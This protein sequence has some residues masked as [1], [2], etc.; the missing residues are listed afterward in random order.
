MLI[1]IRSENNNKKKNT[2]TCSVQMLFFPCVF[3]ICC[4]LGAQLEP[5][6]QQPAACLCLKHNISLSHLLSLSDP[7]LSYNSALICSDPNHICC[8]GFPVSQH[9]S[10][11]QSEFSLQPVKPGACRAFCRPAFVTRSGLCQRCKTTVALFLV[12]KQ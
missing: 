11:K 1:T 2:C 10:Q 3:S 6:G 5:T 4:C 7:H 8:Q 12:R 9:L